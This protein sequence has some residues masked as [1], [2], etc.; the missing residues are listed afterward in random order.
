MLPSHHTPPSLDSSFYGRRPL[1]RWLTLGVILLSAFTLVSRRPWFPPPPPL[2]EHEGGL[3]NEQGQG[4]GHGEYL[5]TRTKGPPGQDAMMGGMTTSTTT[6][7]ATPSSTSTSNEPIDWGKRRDEVR[8]GF[9]HAMKGYKTHAFPHDEL[10]AVS[11]GFSDKYVICDVPSFPCPSL[12]SGSLSS[13]LF[14]SVL[15][16]SLTQRI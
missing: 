1:V 10:L 3:G 12:L 6:A 9:I 13:V 7:Y 16:P 2:F 14:C 5:H 4:Y 15:F 11:G 8:A